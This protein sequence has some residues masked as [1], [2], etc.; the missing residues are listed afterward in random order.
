M[1]RYPIIINNS[2]SSLTRSYQPI[3]KDHKVKEENLAIFPLGSGN[4]IPQ[5]AH[6]DGR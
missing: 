5:V 1:A 4:I 3:E 6:V 2:R